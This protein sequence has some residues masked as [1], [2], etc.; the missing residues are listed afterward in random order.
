MK[1]ITRLLTG[2]ALVVMGATSLA[3]AAPDTK[4][5]QAG[6][7]QT[8]RSRMAQMMFSRLDADGDGAITKDELSAAGPAAAFDKA[9]GNGDG[10][11]EGD[12]LTAFHEARKA[13]REARRQAMMQQRMLDR[14]DANEDG[15]LSLE[16]LE[17]NKRG[18]AA[19]FD[20]LDA[21]D[22]GT[23]TREEMAAAQ[24]Q[25]HKRPGGMRDG[26][27]RRGGERFDRHHG[28]MQGPRGEHHRMDGERM[29]YWRHD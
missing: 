1:R 21:D 15:K 5:P 9:D 19:M 11:L 29:P 4:G 10:V 14:F 28:D 23:V 17:A 8:G 3:V 16:E 12:E 25:M 2:A 26:D 20:R 6:N 7:D 22:D 24:Q 13:E 18:P 27:G